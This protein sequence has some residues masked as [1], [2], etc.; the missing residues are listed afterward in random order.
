MTPL[1]SV[2]VQ[3]TRSS[4]RFAR[5]L[6]TPALL[7]CVMLLSCFDCA[8]A[9]SVDDARSQ[10]LKLDAEW[11]RAAEA[12]SVEAVCG[13]WAVDAVVLPPGRPAVVGKASIRQFVSKS[14]ETPGFSISWKT[15]SVSVSSG[16]DLAYTTGTNRV[17]VTGPDGQH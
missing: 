16:G 6:A 1:F 13:F 4:S 17:T 9:G 8:S 14:F 12:R 15:A 2:R 5:P 7:A 11:S 10:I 3:R